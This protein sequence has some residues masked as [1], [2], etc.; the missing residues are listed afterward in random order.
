MNPNTRL[1]RNPKTEV[2]RELE[3]VQACGRDRGG[4]PR[5]VSEN[6]RVEGLCMYGVQAAKVCGSHCFLAL[7]KGDDDDDDDDDDVFADD[8]A[9]D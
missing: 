8:H 2:N 1:T 5:S 7:L 9:D 3:R 6:L 4:D